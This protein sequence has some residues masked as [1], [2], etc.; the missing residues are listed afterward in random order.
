MNGLSKDSATWLEVDEEAAGQRI[1]NFLLRVCKGVP[2]SHVY[3]ILRSGEVRVNKGRIGPDYRLSVGDAVRVPPIRVAEKQS[4][5]AVPAR[6]FDRVFEDEA[7]LVIDKPCGVAVHGGSGVS[8]GVIEQLRRQR[9]EARLLELA[10]RLDRE[11]SGL[12]IVAK[13]RAA[14]IRLHDM[15]RDGGISKHYLALVKGRWKNVLQHVRLPLLKYLTVEGERRVSVSDEGKAAHSIVRLLARWENFSLV[16]VEL[17]TGRTHQIRVHLAHLGFPLAGDDKYG[18][19]PLNRELQ[20]TGLKRMFLHS[21]RLSFSHPL[22]GNE[23]SLEAPLPQ[24][25]R[26]FLRQLGRN[27]TLN[28][29]E[30]SLIDA[31]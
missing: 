26:D 27:E 25:L 3:R 4:Q 20:K 8:F 7:L 23:M 2:K 21:A 5:A 28:Y 19:F 29:G 13:K 6:E 14:L 30:R 9:P 31:L 16:D 1:D 17:K 24:E 11:T 18:D 15:F 12:L 10:H 22:T